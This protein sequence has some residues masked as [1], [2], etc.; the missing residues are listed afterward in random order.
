MNTLNT[1][2]QVP[3]DPSSSGTTSLEQGFVWAFICAVL[4]PALFIL[5]LGFRLAFPSVD[6]LRL[7]CPLLYPVTQM[8]EQHGFL[9]VHDM[10]KPLIFGVMIPVLF[11]GFAFGVIFGKAVSSRRVWFRHRG[12]I[13]CCTLADIL[14]CGYAAFILFL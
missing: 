5:G 11:T 7:F 6:L 14:F 1:P 13:L 12:L 10:S 2:K 4:S 9:Q 3:N 8:L